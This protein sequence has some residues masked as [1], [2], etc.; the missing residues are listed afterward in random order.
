[1]QLELERQERVHG[2]SRSTAVADMCTSKSANGGTGLTGVKQNVSEGLI[3]NWA[4]TIVKKICVAPILAPQLSFHPPDCRFHRNSTGSSLH[5]NYS[6]GHFSIKFLA[7]ILV[8]FIVKLLFL[9][10]FVT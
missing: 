1:M 3:T 5:C 8:I 2:R 6:M 9:C 7:Q 10:Y 4:I